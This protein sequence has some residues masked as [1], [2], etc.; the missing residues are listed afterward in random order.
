LNGLVYADDSQV[1]R[2]LI[3]KFEPDSLYVFTDPSEILRQA[4]SG[5]PALYVRISDDPTEELV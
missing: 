3:Q 1:H 4:L 2:V 5:P